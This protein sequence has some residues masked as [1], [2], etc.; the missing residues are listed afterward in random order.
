MKKNLRNNVWIL[1]LLFFVL[2][3]VLSFVLVFKFGEI[4]DY[5]IM[6][7]ILSISG[8]FFTLSSL[9]L[10]FILFRVF[11]TSDHNKSVSDKEY[12]EEDAIKELLSSLRI[13]KACIQ[14]DEVKGLYDSCSDVK[15]I[16]HSLNGYEEDVDLKAYSTQIKNLFSLINKHKLT[17]IG[18]EHNSEQLKKKSLK[19]K[20]K[21]MEAAGDL[22]RYLNR[23][24]K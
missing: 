22:E 16:Y 19:D 17:S 3:I 1:F 7:K 21:I 18:F 24:L 5:E 9:I 6:E 23:M 14:K 11:R 10:V 2:P 15:H 4:F 12:L 13:I 8:Y 20:Q